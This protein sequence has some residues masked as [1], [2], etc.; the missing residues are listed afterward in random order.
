MELNISQFIRYSR[1]YGS[2]HDFPDRELL[3]TRKLLNQMFL[4]VCS[5]SDD[6]KVN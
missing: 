2:Y 5:K 3:L 6:R 4:C 1:A